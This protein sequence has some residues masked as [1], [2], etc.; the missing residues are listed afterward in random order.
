MIF[1]IVLNGLLLG[2]LYTLMGTGFSL[3][4][5]ISGIINLSYG[6]MMV[7][8][9][10]IAFF[11]HRLI[12][13]Q[14]IFSIIPAAVVLFFLGMLIYNFLLKPTI[15]KGS[16]IV[17]VIMTFAVE[18]VLE[19]FMLLVWASDYRIITSPYSSIGFDVLHTHLPLIKALIFSISMLAVVLVYLFMNRTKT[20]KSIQAS[21]LNP[22]GAK[23]IGINVDKMYMYNFGI[24]CAIAAVAGALASNIN[25]FSVVLAGGLLAKVFVITVLGGL[26]NIW[27]AALGGITLGLVESIGTITVGPEYN[28]ALGLIV[29][30]IVLVF[31]PRGLIGKKFWDV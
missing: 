31:R 11:L 27:G 9:G 14:P 15:K 5:G 30:V 3:Q 25:A 16:F 29:M 4:W 12:N 23:F 28:E 7:L 2:G 10:Y 18:L 6:G 26:G 24:G 17:T 8:G 19:N 21:A 13:L 1:E 20:G 22:A